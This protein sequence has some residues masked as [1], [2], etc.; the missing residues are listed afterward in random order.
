[1]KV[2]DYQEWKQEFMKRSDPKN[3][4]VIGIRFDGVASSHIPQIKNKMKNIPKDCVEYAI[5]YCSPSFVNA[6]DYRNVMIVLDELDEF[7]SATRVHQRMLVHDS[8]SQFI[9][10]F[11]G[12][13]V[14]YVSVKVTD[15]SR[16][17]L[18]D[19]QRNTKIPEDF[20]GILLE[21]K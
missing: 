1:M 9:S 3:G 16:S 4:D 7:E 20:D 11:V 6:G 2:R 13:H 5:Q 19:L 12:G 14:L 8:P 17:A 10:I 21:G 15:A 18:M